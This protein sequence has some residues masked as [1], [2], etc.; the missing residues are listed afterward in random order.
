LRVVYQSPLRQGA[1]RGAQARELRALGGELGRVED[2]DHVDA[3]VR[4]LV[5]DQR[6]QR[7]G[8][9]QGDAPPDRDA[10]RLEA[11]WAPP[12]VKTPGSVHPGNGSARSMAPVARTRRSNRCRRGPSRVSRSRPSPNTFQTSVPGR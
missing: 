8:P 11:I 1:G 7:A 2:R 9:D 4:V 10:L 3:G 6:Q 12:S 5:R